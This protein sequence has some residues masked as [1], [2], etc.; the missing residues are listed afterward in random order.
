LHVHGSNFLL[1]A[2]LP[3]LAISALAKNAADGTVKGFLTGATIAFAC[4]A[5][6]FK[7]LKFPYGDLMFK[8]AFVLAAVCM[9]YIYFI[10][11]E[12]NTE[13]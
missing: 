2:S 8:G 4:M 10:M 1:L 7:L 3:A 9:V 13:E 6:L 11:P 12:E 5:V